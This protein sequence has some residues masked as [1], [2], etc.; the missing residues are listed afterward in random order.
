MIKVSL[1]FFYLEIFKTRQFRISAYVVLVYIVLNSLAIF[2]LT[3]FSCTP[4]SG[5]WNRDVKAKC[6]DVQGLAYANSAS[7]ILQ[8]IVLLVLPMVFIRHLQMK[9]Y[10]KIFV[11]LMFAIGTF[12]C[13]ATIIRLRTLLSFGFSLDP[14]WD[15]VPV[16]IWTELEL[17]AG[18][19]CVSAPS[20][21]ILI[22]RS[23]P[24]R[25]K[26]FLSQVTH[27]SR[28]RSNPPSNPSQQREREWKKPSSWIN[29][30]QDPK[31]SGHGSMLW[32]RHSLA[33]SNHRQMRSGSR[34]L[35]SA[36][37]DYSDTEG[38]MTGSP[39][40]DKRVDLG[41]EEVEM[42]KVPKPSK[43]AR[44]SLKSHAS[45]DSRITALPPVGKIGMLPEGSYSDL[46]VT[47]LK[48]LGRKWG[49]DNHV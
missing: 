29:I 17:A 5:F 43:S 4:I 49:K 3:L 28:S 47:R 10:R 19:V 6:L 33:P 36:L 42:L 15:Y 21:R 25:F 11:G 30:S 23:L 13:I 39:F 14:T 2:F 7:A 18:F 24:K 35:E 46:N 16:T 26:D 27:S 20:I 32:S 40:M 45:R 8:D 48:G 37:S 9:R 1:V 31:D 41:H 38:G 22:V 44:Q 34:R 12:G